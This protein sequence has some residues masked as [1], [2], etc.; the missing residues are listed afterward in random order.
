MA[1]AP[2]DKR[3]VGRRLMKFGGG[4]M[5]STR[6]PQT[7]DSRR[8]PRVQEGQEEL[9]LDS[10]H[11]TPPEQRNL[12][13]G[14]PTFESNYKQERDQPTNHPFC[15]GGGG[16]EAAVFFGSSPTSHNYFRFTKLQNR[17]P[18]CNSL[19]LM[20]PHPSWHSPTGVDRTTR[21]RWQGASGANRAA[22]SAGVA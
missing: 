6:G 14:L 20:H 11:T 2:A 15:R 4:Y 21:C 9:L 12:A 8:G 3:R 10:Y 13:P 16:T 17:Y 1:N 22:A 18:A 7:T 19:L 5:C